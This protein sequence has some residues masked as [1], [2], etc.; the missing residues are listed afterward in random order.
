MLICVFFPGSNMFSKDR[1]IL[2]LI[3]LFFFLSNFNASVKT[4]NN[5][6]HSD[7]IMWKN[8]KIL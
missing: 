1:K 4:R 8:R 5:L 7:K 6:N 3:F 2:I